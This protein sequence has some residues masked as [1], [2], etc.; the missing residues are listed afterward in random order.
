MTITKE[1][2]KAELGKEYQD[3]CICVWRIYFKK[4]GQR[5]PNWECNMKSI[6]KLLEENIGKTF[7]D[8]NCSNVFLGQSPK[9]IEMKAKINK[10]DLI[11]LKSFAQQR[12][13]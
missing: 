12:K 3:V 8:M 5:G 11:K 7:S 2:E 4:R 13:P 10:R 6:L 1:K 9:A